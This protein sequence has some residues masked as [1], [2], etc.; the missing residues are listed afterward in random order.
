MRPIAH[1]ASGVRR[2]FS[3]LIEDFP[4]ISAALC[5]VVSA[6]LSL[7]PVIAAPVIAIAAIIDFIPF[8]VY[9]CFVFY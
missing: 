6:A 7:H 2:P 5:W 1:S 8:I 9:V 4:I 3:I